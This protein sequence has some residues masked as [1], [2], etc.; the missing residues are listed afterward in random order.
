M[1]PPP[2]SLQA[3]LSGAIAIG[4]LLA[5]LF[6]LRFWRRTRDGLFLSFGVAFLLMSIQPVLA[7][8]LG[9]DSDQMAPI[10]LLRLAAFVLIIVAIWRKNIARR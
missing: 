2:A 3:F 1:S 4:S 8:A 9:F 10:Y 6:F 7:L 5:A